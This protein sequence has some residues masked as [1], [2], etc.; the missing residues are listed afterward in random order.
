MLY[1]TLWNFIRFH[2]SSNETQIMRH[3]FHDYMIKFATNLKMHLEA[4]IYLLQVYL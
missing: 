1:K 3:D 4:T 2:S